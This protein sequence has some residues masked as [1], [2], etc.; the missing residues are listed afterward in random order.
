MRTIARD[1]RMEGVVLPP[2]HEL[3]A[4][5]QTL[6]WLTSPYQFLSECAQQ[7]GDT[8]TLD[9]GSHGTY[10]LVS[11]PDDIRTIFTGDTTQ[12]HAGEGNA[13]LRSFLGPDSLLLLDEQHHLAERR[14]LLRAL[15][16]T[17][18]AA[19][20]PLI[21]A[22][23]LAAARDW[24][25][26]Q[27]VVMQEVAQ[28]ILLEVMTRIVFGLDDG[29]RHAALRGQL[30]A[31][32]DN[33]RL[34]LALLGHLGD[35]LVASEA[36]AT[37][38]QSLARLD[39]LLFAEIGRRRAAR[40]AERGDLLG[41]LLT[42]EQDTGQMRNDHHLRDELLTLLVTGYETTA[43]A[44]A[45]AF[46][47][48]HRELESCR[49]L[50][51]E[52]ATVDTEGDPAALGEL[53]YLE[54]V[55]K[56]TLRLHPVIPLVARQVRRPLRLREYA[57][58]SGITVAPCIY[59]AHHRAERYP[60]PDAFRPDRFLSGEYSPYEFLPFG[61]GARRCLGMSL[62]LH[63]MKLILGTILERYEFE[64]AAAGT[65]RPMRRTVTIAPAGG[66]RLT[67]AKRLR[68]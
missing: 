33:P 53:R 25:P 35:D 64:P 41:A 55:C 5:Q 62:A 31:I 13:I 50:R 60:Q 58:P 3:S 2:R 29:E 37:F 11:R 9:F 45:W 22:V 48:L 59:L 12:L 47:W 20:A 40:H 8:F 66:T 65:V 34:N 54:A 39:G 15:H 44:L 26:G 52:L 28:G 38:N 1:S 43:T 42:A 49:Q 27:S 67:V 68:S 63:E 61:G 4:A 17:P 23:T 10:V 16:H 21:R 19:H 56:E 36:W 32:L 57:I 6:R 46:S 24:A 18:L 14:L 30:R 51:E 7:L